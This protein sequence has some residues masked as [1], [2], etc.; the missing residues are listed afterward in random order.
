MSVPVTGW[1]RACAI[2]VATFFNET[3]MDDSGC[4]LSVLLV[5]EILAENKARVLYP[6]NVLRNLARVQ[7]RTPLLALLDVDMLV[8][9]ALYDHL[10]DRHAAARLVKVRGQGGGSRGGP[11]GG[12]R[13]SDYR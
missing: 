1:L 3:E 2:Q 9:P 8:A 13:D 4:K 10:L 12:W 11:G 7:A 6:I 5:F